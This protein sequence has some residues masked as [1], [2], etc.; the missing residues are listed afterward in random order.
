ML[1]RYWAVLVGEGAEGEEEGEEGVE[2]RVREEVCLSDGDFARLYFGGL[3]AFWCCWNTTLRRMDFRHQI[4]LL[5]SV[6]ICHFGW[7]SLLLCI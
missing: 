1:W 5:L 3:V 4:S 2:W 7:L 6:H